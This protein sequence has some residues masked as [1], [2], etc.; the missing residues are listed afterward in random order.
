M[1]TSKIRSF[2]RTTTI[3]NLYYH[4]NERTYIHVYEPC[5][6]IFDI[7][8]PTNPK[9][10]TKREPAN[11]KEKKKERKGLKIDS[12]HNG[13]TVYYS[14]EGSMNKRLDSIVDIGVTLYVTEADVTTCR[15]ED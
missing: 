1:H 2:L 3:F 9:T 7:Y 13:G 8:T 10:R 14:F 15:P 12:G 5:N 4:R 6:H 11:R